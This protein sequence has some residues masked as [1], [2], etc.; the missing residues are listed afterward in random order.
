MTL[1]V[2][3]LL[4]AFIAE[5]SRIGGPFETPEMF[6]KALDRFLDDPRAREAVV[7]AWWDKGI[8]QTIAHMLSKPPIR[9]SNR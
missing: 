4:E 8:H 9:A 1:S 2:V 6:F 7:E 5:H 3:D